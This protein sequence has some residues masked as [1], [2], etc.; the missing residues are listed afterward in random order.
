MHSSYCWPVMPLCE[1]Q[2]RDINPE[3][4]LCDG[5]YRRCNIYKGGGGYDKFEAIYHRRFHSEEKLNEQFVVQLLGCPLRCPY[6]YVT[7]EGIRGQPARVS[8]QRLVSDF[9]DSGLPVF[10]LM[11]GAPAIYLEHW[12]K[13]LA[14]LP[15]SAVFHSDFLL[16]EFEYP[17]H[18]L[19]SI[20]KHKRNLHAVSVKGSNEKE[21]L[22]NTGVSF[23]KS[24]FWKNLDNLVDTG[25][26]FYL[27]YT[28]MP[29]ES[30]DRFNEVAV[31]RYGGSILRDSFAIGI[32]QYEA[33]KDAPAF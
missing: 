24:M 11:G 28:G 12:P 5:L 25:M 18:T 26:Q 29:Q 19:E 22:T 14:E 27:T 32:V 6:C 10:H 15:D 13:L 31:K 2:L 16:Q 23:N 4:V 3:D 21:F 33:I 8:T 9:K 17:V 1:R 20:A 7:E 30:I